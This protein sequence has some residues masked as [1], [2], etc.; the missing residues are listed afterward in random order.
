MTVANLKYRLGA[1]FVILAT[2]S[3]AIA[4]WLIVGLAGWNEDLVLDWIPGSAGMAALVIIALLTADTILPIPA[5]IVMLASGAILGPIAGS[6]VNAIGL[7]VAAGA[8]YLLGRS[9]PRRPM[10]FASIRPILVTTTRGLPVLSE[11]VAIGAGIVGYPVQRFLQAAALG[12]LAVGSLYGV[13]GWQATNHWSLSILA[14]ML[15][16]VSYLLAVHRVRATSLRSDTASH[17]L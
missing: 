8:G 10:N 6:I 14:C 12:A 11:S 13:A 5:T 4:I 15:A 16:A 9:L 1:A 3:A 7:G 17:G 2:A